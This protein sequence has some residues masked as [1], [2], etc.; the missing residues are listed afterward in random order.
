MSHKGPIFGNLSI[1]HIGISFKNNIPI[2]EPALASSIPTLSIKLDF[3]G[4][5]ATGQM[6]KLTHPKVG[7]GLHINPTLLKVLCDLDPA[8]LQVRQP[9]LTTLNHNPI[10][11]ATLAVLS[12]AYCRSLSALLY[13][14]S[15]PLQIFAKFT[16]LN[17]KN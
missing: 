7:N 4:L 17:S 2:S 8:V 16:E 13:D 11:S 5:H 12:T 6:R 1:S 15:T 14:A 10:E 9:S 3:K